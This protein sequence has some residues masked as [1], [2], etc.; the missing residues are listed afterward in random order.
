VISCHVYGLTMLMRLP[1]WLTVCLCLVRP[2]NP[3]HALAARIITGRTSLASAA[4]PSAACCAT[5]FT[6]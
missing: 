3:L 5:I 1:A 2:A 4:P 6:G